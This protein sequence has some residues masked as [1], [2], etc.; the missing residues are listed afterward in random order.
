M[1]HTW[2]FSHFTVFISELTARAY[3]IAESHKRRTVTRADISQAAGQSDMF[4]FLIDFLPP[5]ERKGLSSAGTARRAAGSSKGQE[6]IPTHS[7]D[8]RP[9]MPAVSAL[10]TTSSSE[11]TKT[12][13]ASSDATQ[14]VEHHV[15]L[16]Y[17]WRHCILFR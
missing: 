4:D 17:A 9:S 8:H 16:I 5:D 7:D 6:N 3:M 15:C 2:V 10:R 13:R 12:S 11:Q 14:E 1:A